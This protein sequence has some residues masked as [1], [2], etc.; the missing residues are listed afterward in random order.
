MG[1]DPNGYLIFGADGRMI[2]LVTG[3]AAWD[4]R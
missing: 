3:T 2:V 4:Y 1:A